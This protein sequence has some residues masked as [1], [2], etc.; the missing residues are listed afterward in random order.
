MSLSDTHGPAS[1]RR[2]PQ[3]SNIF[4]SE[5]ACPIKANFYVEP[6]LEGWTKICSRHLGQ[7]TKMAAMRI[8]GKRLR[9][10]SS[11][12]RRADFHET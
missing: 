3:C 7:M 5:T 11:T 9:K 10:S 12:E 4:F 6:S 2:R 1:V 8:Y